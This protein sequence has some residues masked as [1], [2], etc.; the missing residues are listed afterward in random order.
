MT[1]RFRKYTLA[2]VWCG[3]VAYGLFEII[4]PNYKIRINDFKVIQ[5]ALETY[6]LDNGTYPISD[7]AQSLSPTWIPG[8]APKYLSTVPVDPRKL[9]GVPSR[10]YLYLSDGR[11][12]KLISHAPEDFKF[13]SK[14]FPQLIDPKRNTYAYGIWTEGAQEW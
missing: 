12:Y 11:E 9:I 5:S 3:I 2:L 7:G 8:L 14:S 6:K 10:Q 4:T 13:V 1:Q